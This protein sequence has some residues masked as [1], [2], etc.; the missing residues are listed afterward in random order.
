MIEI[1]DKCNI[2]DP[3]PNPDT[4]STSVFD[5]LRISIIDNYNELE[6]E[7]QDFEA[8]AVD[9]SSCSAWCRAWYEAH[10]TNKH[11]TPFIVIGKSPNGT[12]Q[13]LLPFM[14][15]T[16]GPFQLLVRPGVKHSAYFSG[17]FSPELAGDIRGGDRPAFWRHV[18]ASMP[19]IDVIW[20]EGVP[21]AR[22]SLFAGEESFSSSNA[23]TSMQI[24][25][26]WDSQYLEIFNS[27]ARNNDKRGQRNLA[28]LGAVK[29]SVVT[30]RSAQDK[31][32]VDMLAQKSAAL[33]KSGKSSP[34]E[35]HE[36]LEFY[37]RLLAR[38]EADENTKILLSK[39]SVD[40]EL[41]AANLGV[42]FN[43]R[44]FGMIIST[45]DSDARRHSP[46][47][48]LLLEFNRYLSQNGI[49]AHDF[50]T[51]V[52]EYKNNW[53]DQTIERYHVLMPSGAKGKF[54]ARV[55]RSTAGLKAWVKRSKYK[56]RVAAAHS[57][58]M[59]ARTAMRK[60]FT[61]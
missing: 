4:S 34:F 57:W 23:C 17:I 48:L 14:K 45:T 10:A 43:N 18:M 32:L 15:R 5:D 9:Y 13:F 27:K 29:F 50:G 58:A 28:K 6:A 3:G 54:L 46:G 2:A 33:K 47:R 60:H 26:D 16:L 35:D 11:L 59:R 55:I 52:A 42:L 31:L 22:M 21:Q 38:Y 19:Q 61:N 36:S 49:A 56:S 53:C 39:L 1:E 41:M 30:E 25:S 20:L 8:F 51:G 44:F 7:W 12:I 37:R 40:D 24:D